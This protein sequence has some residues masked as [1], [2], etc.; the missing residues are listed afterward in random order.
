[1]RF[2][3]V[4]RTTLV[5]LLLIAY[6]GITQ[7]FPGVVLSLSEKTRPHPLGV[8]VGILIGIRNAGVFRRNRQERPLGTQSR[9][10]G[11]VPQ[12]RGARDHDGCDAQHRARHAS[13]VRWATSRAI[14]PL[15]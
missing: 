11:A 1:L 15:K 2:W 9:V 10:R 8:G 12:R 6:T 14:S 4:A 7:F 13:I 5:G 3:A